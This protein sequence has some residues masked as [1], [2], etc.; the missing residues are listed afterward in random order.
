[1]EFEGLLLNADYITED[2]RAV[3][4]LW[5]KDN[6]GNNVVIFDD[7]FQ[8]Y[9]YVLP[10]NQSDLESD[11]EK[12]RNIWASRHDG[13]VSLD[14]VEVVER[15]YLGKPIKVFRVTA[16]HPQHVPSLREAVSVSGMTYLEADILF[17]IR[18]LI[19]KELAP[20][21]GVHAK[22]EETSVEY[23]DR[24]IL[25]DS[26]TH[27]ELSEYPPI[28][29][30]AFDCEMATPYGMP[31]PDKDPIVILSVAS[32]D[33]Q[34]EL[35]QM[36]GESDE[37]V[38]LRF[39][40]FIHDVNPDVIVGYNSDA[41]DWPYIRDRAKK[42]GIQLNVGTDGS[43]PRFH[44]AG[45]PD[46]SLMG[47]L[48]IDLYKI[49]R[50][51]LGDVKVK[52]LENV[53]EYMGVMDRSERVELPARDIYECWNNPD[54]RDDLLRYAEAD[55]V[56]TL[57]LAD[58]L[59]PLQHEF[60]KMTHYPLDNVS[61]MGRG[62]QVEAFLTAEAHK[63]GEL[64][65]QKGGGGQPYEGAFVLEPVK[66]VHENVVCLD[67]SSMYPSIMISFNISPDTVASSPVDEG[68]V[69]TAPEVGHRFFKGPDGFFKKI[70]MQLVETR[71]ELKQEMQELDRDSP[72][73]HVLDIRQNTL[74][75][76]TNSFYGYTGWN[77]ARWYRRECAEATTAFG[78]HFIRKA[79]DIAEDAGLEVLYGDTDSL[80]VKSSL[81]LEEM[82][83]TARD[84]ASK[85]SEE[86]PLDLEIN[87]IYNVIFF[88]GKKKRYAGL[89]TDGEIVVKGLEVRRGDW[90]ELAKEMQTEV[91]RII[92]EERDPAKAAELVQN[93]VQ[94]IQNGEIA[95]E[96]L[97][98]YKT[99]TK[100]I[101][102]Y[103]TR[104]THVTA[105]KRAKSQGIHYE[106]G[107][108]IPYVILKGSAIVSERAYPAELF[109]SEQHDLD[110]DYYVNKQVIPV[111]VRILGHF[112][113]DES[114][115]VDE[116]KQ[117]TLDQWF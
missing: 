33:D 106:V 81:E 14:K 85:I 79:M 88:T 41:F 62:R 11:M 102:S 55:V 101:S 94:Q 24:A 115:L 48:N 111:A 40:Q 58:K 83:N 12:L 39:V 5:C 98:I 105:A 100:K 87:E 80:F 36:E 93:T 113:Y 6:D 112:G 96:K 28:R 68:D 30:M 117:G 8:P 114:E 103:D 69:Y 21:N 16:K 56:S 116:G 60:A 9:F 32:S 59:L 29:F 27:V 108:K 63:L 2:E 51:D 92:L 109:D 46:V 35:F 70:L 65:P 78:R 23:V 72:E 49:A 57:G 18:Y 67:F 19:D 86:M 82:L 104:Q 107:S 54:R 20:M 17:A 26:I 50:R 52:K 31:S 1:M 38:I 95:F 66:G 34:L 3:I 74:K 76:L 77:A 75:I 97:I 53:A 90:C 71:R 73:H 10:N 91:I 42:H 110:A 44:G 99:L 84:L 61:K 47:R 7:S 15:R 43:Q 13:S 45:L 22:G 4:R 64:V 37:S 89:T 25:A